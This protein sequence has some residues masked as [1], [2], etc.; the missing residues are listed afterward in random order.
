MMLREFGLCLSV[1]FTIKKKRFIFFFTKL[2]FNRNDCIFIL[3]IYINRAA[4][5]YLYIPFVPI[6]NVLCYRQHVQFALKKYTFNTYTDN[7]ERKRKV[8]SIRADENIHNFL[9]AF[10]CLLADHCFYFCFTI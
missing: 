3:C 4:Y 8:H 10:Y 9:F 7:E 5:I 6:S 1:C 2:L